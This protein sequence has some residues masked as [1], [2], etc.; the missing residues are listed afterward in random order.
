M[1][2][3][4]IHQSH[5]QNFERGYTLAEILTILII[6]GILMAL[7]V[8]SL[9]AMQG[10]AKLNNALDNLR[11]VL[12][13]SQ[14]QAIQRKPDPNVIDPITGLK[15]IDTNKLCKVSIP[16]ELT[17]IPKSTSASVRATCVANVNL[18]S[19]STAMTTINNDI[20]IYAMTA[21]WQQPTSAPAPQEIIYNSQGLT[22]NGG[23]IIL[24]STATSEQRCLIL[25][26]GVGLIRSGKYIN[27]DC[28]IT[29]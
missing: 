28:E 5:R 4:P 27:S 9:I 29:E 20:T 24:S 17:T 1:L 6:V 23:M 8:P 11:T 25:N 22:Q 21:G 12:E 7:A 15:S 18:A 19:D 14:F 3:L 10:V 26:A 13:T 16:R 2:H